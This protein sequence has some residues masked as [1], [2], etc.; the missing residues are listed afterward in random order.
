MATIVK[1][2]PPIDPSMDFLGLIELK[3]FLNIFL[4]IPIP[5]KYAKESQT[6]TNI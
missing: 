2:V 5:T 1:T 6:Q 3:P 4:P